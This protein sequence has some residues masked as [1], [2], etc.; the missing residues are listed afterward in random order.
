[1]MI[2]FLSKPLFPKALIPYIKDSGKLMTIPLLILSLAAITIGYLVNDLFISYGSTFFV[3][4]IYVHPDNI[5][6]LDAS[7]AGSKLSIIPLFFLLILLT[8][9]VFV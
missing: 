6:I 2:T 7:N 9:M 1:M 4:S 5:R 3:N 8:S